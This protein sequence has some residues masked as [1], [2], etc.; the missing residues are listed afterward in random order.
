MC[1]AEDKK[2]CSM[3]GMPLEK[4]AILESA[5]SQNATSGREA[6]CPNTSEYSKIQGKTQDHASQVDYN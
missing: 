2:R 6:S 3:A 1:E 4:T 5:E